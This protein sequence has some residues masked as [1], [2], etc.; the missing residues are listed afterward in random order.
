MNHSVKRLNQNIDHSFY[1]E[2]KLTGNQ[3]MTLEIF[4]EL[5]RD[6]KIKHTN[7][8]FSANPTLKKV[9]DGE[10]LYTI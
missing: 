6:N 5:K 1:E 10:Y 4:A 2:S 8:H 7:F 3:F 9:K